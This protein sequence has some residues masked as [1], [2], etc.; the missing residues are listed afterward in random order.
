MSSATLETWLPKGKLK[1]YPTRTPVRRPSGTLWPHGE[2]SLGYAAPRPDGGD[3]H[4][5][6]F[7][8]L[9]VD[10]VPHGR[11]IAGEV[12]RLN[13]SDV[14]NSTKRPRRGLKGLTGY[15]KN[16]VK[17]FGFLLQE[18]YPHHRVTLGTV[19][20]PPMG[21]Q[22]RREVVRGWS[23]LVREYLRWL[24]RRLERRGLPQVVCSVTE[25]Q[26][27]RLA[28]QNEGYLHLHTLW[29]NRPAKSG[30]WAIDPCELRS[31]L[32]SYLERKIPS[33]QGGHVNVNVKPVEGEVARYMAKY[34]S[35]GGDC[36]TEALADWGEDCC[37]ATWW[38][39]TAPAREWVKSET[40]KGGAVGEYIETMLHYLWDTS[41]DSWLE[42]L[43]HVELEFDGVMITVGYRG[44][45][46][47]GVAIDAR[48]MLKSLDIERL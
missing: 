21:Q 38:N 40:L 30:N 28:T 20:L 34:M 9:G 32:E 46:E 2:F 25:I 41:D 16:M 44:R 18:K 12:A 10:D 43:R 1:G 42:F 47:K 8:G 45:M 19:T 13:L 6:P 27:K 33:Y 5:D 23:D 35:K 11:D 22:A 48:V 14:R 24:S 26:P 17:A 37:P 4:E 15:G 7:V 36:L 31:W 29:L 39:M 3:W